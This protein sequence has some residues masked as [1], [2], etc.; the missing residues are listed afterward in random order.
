[1]KALPLL[2][3]LLPFAS[4]ASTASGVMGDWMGPTNSVV[5]IYTCG[6]SVCAKIVKLAKS[7][8][9]KTDAN[10]PE[11]GKRDRP[12][13]GLDIGTG[14]R[15]VDA[16]HLAD[17]RLYDPKSGH[18]YSGTITSEGNDLKLHGYIGI[19]LLGRTEVW[20][21]VSEIDEKSCGI[22]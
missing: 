8:P 10:N 21:R 20:H 4:S 22:G 3:L 12:L 7:S 14:F 13:C 2:L 9:D 5:R 19:S 17:G 18:T 6:S 11:S 1:M 15:K 16:D